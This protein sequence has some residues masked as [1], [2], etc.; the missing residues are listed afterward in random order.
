MASEV[1]IRRTTQNRSGFGE[2][3]EF[4][5]N[6]VLLCSHGAYRRQSY[7][8]YGLQSL[9]ARKASVSIVCK[10]AVVYRD[11]CFNYV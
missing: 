7:S 6:P 8:L 4:P 2:I 9:Q 5:G 3:F 10:T 11:T 1:E